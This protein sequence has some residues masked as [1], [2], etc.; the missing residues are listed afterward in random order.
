MR[1][2]TFIRVGI[3]LEQPWAVGAVSTV[4]DAPTVEDRRK[5][6]RARRTGEEETLAVR[7][8]MQR[9]P[10]Q[11][12][13]DAPY[14]P[15]TSLVGGLREHLRG[16]SGATFATS[17][18]GRPPEEM[19]TSVQKWQK[20]PERFP[21]KLAALGVR[22]DGGRVMRSGQTAIDPARGAAEANMLRESQRAEADSGGAMTAVWLLHYDHDD[23]DGD[24]ADQGLLDAIATWVPWVGRGRSAGQGLARVTAVD[25]W[26]LDLKKATHLSWWL[27]AR[28]QWFEHPGDVAL[29]P[30][31]AY[32]KAEPKAGSAVWDSEVEWV[33]GDPIAPGSGATKDAEPAAN[34]DRRGETRGLRRSA[35][36]PILPGTSLKGIFRHRTRWMLRAVGADAVLVDDVTCYLFGYSPA[37][38]EGAYRGVLRFSD[39]VFEGGSEAV[40]EYAH[41]AI[42]RLTGGARS[43][44]LYF[45]EAVR[46]G[47]RARTRI[48][49]DVELQA[50]V[51]DL[52]EW[53]YRD[54]DDG[55]IGV[56]G[57]ESRGYG[58][59]RLAD[60]SRQR[61]G[62]I[63]LEGLREAT[64]RAAHGEVQG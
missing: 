13:P 25:A 6:R 14:L 44:A 39:T 16:Q 12:R 2:T 23:A 42:D 20:R 22:L 47:T 3:A 38:G 10:E 34:E 63:D 4:A 64:P 40:A 56:G 59:L 31:G 19:P 18:L 21:S 62:R 11:L 17:W 8:P 7:A 24:V 54:L 43:G 55:L 29:E 27:G 45:V 35:G 60:R 33:T 30:P 36:K 46:P 26:T 50:S 51:V 5:A 32:V 37:S 58:T 41:V 52:L 57:S 53:V 1:R 9:W 49:S 15:A 61:P 48:E 28:H